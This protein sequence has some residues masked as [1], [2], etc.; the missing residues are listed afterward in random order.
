MRWEI[1]NRSG[2]AGEKTRVSLICGEI[3]IGARRDGS[4]PPATAIGGVRTVIELSCH[5]R[6]APLVRVYSLVRPQ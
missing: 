2:D 6:L 4:G 1:Y 5:A 3:S